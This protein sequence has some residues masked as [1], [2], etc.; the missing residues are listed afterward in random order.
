MAYDF[1]TQAR[2]G[3][4]FYNIIAKEIVRPLFTT[5]WLQMLLFHTCKIAGGRYIFLVQKK[6]GSLKKKNSG[7]WDRNVTG[8]QGK[9][10]S[11]MGLLCYCLKCLPRL[12]KSISWSP[13]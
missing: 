9:T 3:S 12:V 2:T 7:D 10:E 5:G 4:I 13:S 1:K 11:I 8:N 6:K